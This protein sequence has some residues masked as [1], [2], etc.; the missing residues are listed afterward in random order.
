MEYIN[1][2][3]NDAFNQ[4]YIEPWLSE[5]VLKF[6]SNPENQ[7][8]R[9]DILEGF[10]ECALATREWRVLFSFYSRPEN[11]E[12]RPDI[13][14]KALEIM[15]EA[16]YWEDLIRFYKKPENQKVRPDI[17]EKTLEWTLEKTLGG[18]DTLIEFY[19]EKENQKVRRD[20]LEKTLEKL[21][22]ENLCRFYC[23][24]ENQDVRPDILEKFLEKSWEEERWDL[25]F[26]FYSK[27]EN[28]K[29]R[30]DIL[31]KLL[32]KAYMY[33]YFD[34]LLKFY[35]EP[36]KQK[37]RPDIFNSIINKALKWAFSKKY[38]NLIFSFYSIPQNQVFERDILDKA[39][40]EALNLNRWARQDYFSKFYSN[41]ENRKN[42]PEILNRWLEKEMQEG[43][44]DFLFKFYS[45]LD[46]E[47]FKNNGLIKLLDDMIKNR[48]WD[49]ILFLYSTPEK[50]KLRDDMID[51]LG[52]AVENVWKAAKRQL[53]IPLDAIHSFY[54]NP[55]NQNIRPD[56]FEE[57]LDSL[58]YWDEIIR[59]YSNPKNRASSTI[60]EFE[61]LREKI[62][63]SIKRIPD[64]NLRP[65]VLEH[66]IKYL[67]SRRPLSLLVLSSTDDLSLFIEGD[68][69][70]IKEDVI[71]SWELDEEEKNTVLSI[72]ASLIEKG[73][74]FPFPLPFKP[75]EDI[76]KT[77]DYKDLLISY[78][79]TLNFI[80][81]ILEESEEKAIIQ[82]HFEEIK[83]IIKKYK[84]EQTSIEIP[85]SFLKECL[86]SVKKLKA[87]IIRIIKSEFMI[88]E[89]IKDDDLERFIKEC[90]F[91][92]TLI[93]LGSHYKKIY[94]D[95][96]SLLGKIV[97]SLIKNRYFEERYNLDDALTKD[98]L[99]P[100]LTYYPE[101][102]YK[103]I[104]E[105]WRNPY[106]SVFI[107]KK[108]G[109]KGEKRFNRADIF[110][111]L[112][113][114]IITDKHFESLF[115]IIKMDSEDEDTI[116]KALSFYFEESKG[117]LNW[118]DIKKVLQKYG[119]EK[120]KID[121]F[122]GILSILKEIKI[123][124]KDPK[125]I[126]SSLDR[127]S[128]KIKI[129]WPD[130]EKVE[131]WGIDLNSYLRNVLMEEL[132]RGDSEVIK[133]ERVYISYLTDHPKTLLEI[134][135][136]PVPTCQS[137]ESK[138]D[139]NR[140]LLGYVFDA[141]IK[142][143]VLREIYSPIK[144]TQE[145]IEKSKIEIDEDG[146]RIKI[147]T[148]EGNRIEGTIS[149]PI[150]RRILM[151]GRKQERP[152]VLLEPIY[153]SKISREDADIFLSSPISKL[154]E[155]FKEIGLE[156]GEDPMGIELPPSHNP[157]GFYRD[158]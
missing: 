119:L 71:R 158:I 118:E 30:S 20:I 37:I 101:E 46:D 42:K 147:V 106:F 1:F 139:L 18:P 83:E 92:R 78:F 113:R 142:A 114:R 4:G 63:K 143:A 32:E 68:L 53:A 84:I 34:E 85:L 25:L 116:R 2:L 67:K 16:R 59:F 58:K 136:Y 5:P 74:S 157:A 10:L 14:E 27:P 135:K 47:E 87:E 91:L 107:E 3:I 54:S 120:E 12:F 128:D 129:Y 102:K 19:L 98:Q 52:K 36:E 61:E 72:F 138:G 48:Q 76:K 11:R 97:S 80:A 9:P 82:K 8:I 122:L 40:E 95:G 137:F 99:S 24:P 15:L 26:W 56:I 111:E 152:Y 7:K 103:E 45:S 109:V 35:T 110:N 73:I 140:Y 79:A 153:Y 112:K 88:D 134:G 43:N 49:S 90:K 21:G 6:Y 28:C 96:L 94:P 121:I 123:G 81:Y 69:L 66:Y 144:L 77:K 115:K 117:S 39:L 132:R 146:E 75:R 151:L 126:L 41:S 33:R 22:L 17:L 148:P 149:K 55:E 154:E 50:R 86:N 131:G 133:G 29:I 13:L 156:I 51:I 65:I 155:A 125:E 23:R 64:E 44:Y 60:K 108:G 100:I 93:V 130:L 150:A 31:D 62:N 70:N 127:L 38:W 124:Q 89:S 105:K 145:I 104:I 141:H 57:F